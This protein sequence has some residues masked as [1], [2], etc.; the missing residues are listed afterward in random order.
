MSKK[1]VKTL[2]DAFANETNIIN[3]DIA[4]T[5]AEFMRISGANKNLYRIAPLI[6][7]GL[8]PVE[9]RTLYTYYMDV[10]KKSGYKLTKVEKWVGNTL[11]YHPHG[12]T[13]VY[14]TI[15]GMAQEWN[16]NCCL[17]Y[18]QGNFGNISGDPAAAGRYINARLTKFAYKCFFEN[19]EHGHV[20]MQPTYT[21]D[22]MEPVY[23]PARYPYLLLNG[24]LGIGY[25]VAANIPPF[26]LTEVFEA[27]MALMK[28][29][30]ANIYLVPDFPTGAS[31]VDR[32]D[33][34]NLFE[35]GKGSVLS[36]AVVEV[37]ERS[38]TLTITKIPFRTSMDGIKK[39]IVSAIVAKKYPEIERYDDYTGINSGKTG[40]NFRIKLQK[41]VNPKKFLKKLYKGGHDLEKTYPVDMLMVRY[42]HGYIFCHRSIRQFLLDWIQ[43]RRSHV[44]AALNNEYVTLK[45]E[46]IINEIIAFITDPAIKDKAGTTNA[47]KTISMF[48]RAS[49]RS[50]IEERL[51]S[52]FK[53]IP[54][55]DDFKH[56]TVKQPLTRLQA[57]TISSLGLTRFLKEERQKVLQKIQEIISRLKELMKLILDPHGPDEVIIK[58]LEEGI[59]LFGEPRRSKIIKK[60]KND[61]D[62]PDVDRVVVVTKSGIIQKINPNEPITDISSSEPIWTLYTNDTDSIVAFDS[63]GVAGKIRVVDIPYTK[64]GDAGTPIGRYAK[65]NGDVVNIL[66]F[67]DQD[68]RAGVNVLLITKNGY[69]KKVDVSDLG[70]LIKPVSVTALDPGDEL[71]IAAYVMENDTSDII[72]STNLGRGWRFS[73][74]EIPSYR[75]QAR[76]LKFS[77][78]PL[79]E[80]IVSADL[81]DSKRKYLFYM[82][83]KGRGKVTDIKY[84][85][86][87]KRRTEPLVLIPLTAKE[88]LVGIFSCS[89]S[90]EFTIMTRN[91]LRVPIKVSD[92]SVT[93]R[94]NKPDKLIPMKGDAVVKVLVKA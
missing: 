6:N 73:L 16:N 91:G 57:R 88:S 90:D 80:F 45:E 33:F 82:T 39:S 14:D 40:V 55:W 89:K 37:D 77:D 67:V 66:P 94:A 22:D 69:V 10:F 65:L 30:N 12:S 59:E 62:I 21:G 35:T 4:D 1:K 24:L 11:S 8:K 38:N 83:S 23:L 51:L 2:S 60:S 5:C 76:G 49:S 25:T 74:S 19:F 61:S 42:R 26:N 79:D 64:K 34:K 29:P 70:E 86:R 84:L 81:I 7:D 31:V 28:N 32:G 43:Y 18:G 56:K 15:V 72:M 75:R 54:H 20:P 46:L 93:G 68:M 87:S 13:G 52:N 78:I 47:E 44:A 85:P 63:N 17:V 48:Q 71:A 36:R 41:D 50:E 58:E 53:S 92:L 27:T 9:R 3:Q